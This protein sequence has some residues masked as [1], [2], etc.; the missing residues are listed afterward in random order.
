[1]FTPPPRRRAGFTLIE[2][3]VVIAIIAVLIGLLLPAVQAAREAARR[4]QC[5][6]NLKQIGLA[7]HN[8]HDSHNAFPPG[9]V[10]FWKKDGGDAGTAEDD[11]GPGWAWGSMILPQLEQS[12]V[13]NVI[14]FSLTVGMTQNSTANLLR[15]NSYLCP[16]DSP[17]PSVPVRDEAN[18]MTVNHVGTSNYVGMYGLGEVGEAPGRGNGTFFRNSRVGLRDMLDGS[19]QT[20][21]VGERSHN[22]S[23][24][25]WTSRSPGGWLFKTSSFEGGTDTFAVDPEE[26]FTM[27][28]GP[29]GLEHGPRTP[30]HPMAHVE[31]YWS[32]H[33]GGVNF[34]FGDGSVKFIKNGIAPASFQALATRAGSEVLSADA[35]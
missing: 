4:S 13:Y 24:V 16:S 25:T 30:N 12:A 17:P 34:V 31:D 33:P 35:Y 14:N 7:L 2:L 1:M 10:S 29:V 5:I 8:Y 11:Y 26:A 27:V 15:F 28:L 23:F 9:Y 18:T 21:I 20:I 19:S 6:N 22:L 32:R 3:L